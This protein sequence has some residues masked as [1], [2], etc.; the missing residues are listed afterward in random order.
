MNRLISSLWAPVEH[1]FASPKTLRIPTKV[2]T[3]PRHATAL[4][5][6]LLALTHHQVAR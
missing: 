3:H 6:A 2:R 4:V 5:R 1:G